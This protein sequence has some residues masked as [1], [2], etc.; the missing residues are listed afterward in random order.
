[1]FADALGMLR[2][3]S[4][5]VLLQV[6]AVNSTLLI[7]AVTFERYLAICRPLRSATWRTASRAKLTIP[8]VFLFSVVYSAP[9]LKTSGLSQDLLCAAV[10]KHDL[11]SKFWAGW[12]LAVNFALPFCLLLFMNTFIVRAIHCRSRHLDPEGVRMKRT[13]KRSST[14]DSIFSQRN[15]KRS[16]TI[17]SCLSAGS[18]HS[19]KDH[20]MR[21]GFSATTTD[22]SKSTNH[23]V[24]QG[25]I[26]TRHHKRYGN[27]KSQRTK[28]CDT[29]TSPENCD[30][31]QT[32]HAGQNQ[33]RSDDT[34][35]TTVFITTPDP[36]SGDKDLQD[37]TDGPATCSRNC[38]DMDSKQQR[39]LTAMLLVVTT[40]FLLLTSPQYV[41]YIVF[42]CLNITRD[43]ETFASAVLLYHITNKCFYTNSAVNFFLYCIAGSKF[44]KDVRLF[45]RRHCTRA[46]PELVSTVRSSTDDMLHEHH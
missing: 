11:G 36:Q 3:D 22:H 38:G 23:S 26:P 1:M 2:R 21:N 13:F 43:A 15:V 32:T 16:N 5:L 34:E 24:D 10:A 45:W 6:C 17:N 7:L 27:W 9:Y 12:G 39:Q 29:N 33:T 28:S 8:L 31:A 35:Q 40:T 20:K 25:S 44:R 42:S 14:R 46:R 18:E 37:M 4:S 19:V 41:R 30:D